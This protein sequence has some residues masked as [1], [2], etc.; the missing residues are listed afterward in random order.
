MPANTFRGDF[1][2]I[3]VATASTALTGGQLVKQEGHW[4]L[5]ITGVAVGLSTQLD[6][7]GSHNIVVPTGTVKGDA[8]WSDLSAGADI[9]P[10]VLTRTPVAG[11][12]L[13]G[14]ALTDRASTKAIIQ[15]APEGITYNESAADAAELHTLAT[16][17][18]VTAEPA[19]I[20]NS[21]GAS[22]DGTIGAVTNPTLSWNGSTD[23][24]AQQATDI[25]AAITAL[26]A[27]VT[28]LATKQNAVIV[29]LQT[30]G[31]LA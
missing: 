7:Q 14:F 21:T 2:H 16:A 25:N 29:K 13:I 20:D 1:K 11:Y 24:T 9:V 30:A 12:T 15:L 10:L 26:K 19:L 6:R 22:A 5:V 3:P 27:A 8:I 28:E 23:P 31:I 17:I 18:P 4:G